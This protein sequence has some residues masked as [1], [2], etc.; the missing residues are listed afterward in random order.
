[1]VSE[2]LGRLGSSIAEFNQQLDFV[3]GWDCHPFSE[4]LLASINTLSAI[5]VTVLFLYSCSASLCMLYS[6]VP[7]V[8]RF[9]VH[10]ARFVAFNY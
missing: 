1:M 2:F 6:I 8:N 10:N 3:N 7:I 9:F 5:S 4:T